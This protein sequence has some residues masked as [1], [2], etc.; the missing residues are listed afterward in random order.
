VL[1]SIGW[2]DVS[3]LLLKTVVPPAVTA[4][5]CCV[6]GLSVE[7]ATTEVPRATSRGLER[8]VVAMFVVT[9]AV[10]ILTYL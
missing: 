3:N 10:S 6:E 8:S 9:T 1:T 4:V 2:V 5:I 7:G